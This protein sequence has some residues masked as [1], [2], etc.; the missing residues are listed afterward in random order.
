MKIL[1]FA[2]VILLTLQGCEIN[3]EKDKA[4][5]PANPMIGTWELV[6]GTTIQGK[7]TTTTD[8]TKGKKFLKVIN[9]THFSFVDMISVKEKILRP[10][11]LQVPEPIHYLTACI[12][13]I[14]NFA[15]TG[16]GRVMISFLLW[17]FKM[18]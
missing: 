9:D 11:I 10:F 7:D 13:N 15:A 18:I 12:P 3:Q 2:A 6:T 17:H 5:A 14:Y 16:P 8:Y 1:T 4:V